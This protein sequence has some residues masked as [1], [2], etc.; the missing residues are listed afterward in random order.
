MLQPTTPP[1]MTT[2]SALRG[3]LMATSCHGR[4]ANDRS[5]GLA[6]RHLAHLLNR[7]ARLVDGLVA[8]VGA[9]MTL[10]VHAMPEPLELALELGELVVGPLLEVDERRACAFDPAQQLVELEVN[11]LRIAVLR[12]LDEEHHEERHDR[13]A[14]VDHQLPR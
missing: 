14:G 8:F 6:L 13:G 2:T 3:R 10:L 11:G 1:P 12:V 5:G 9:R 7:L 4:L